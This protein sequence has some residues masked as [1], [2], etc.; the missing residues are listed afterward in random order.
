MAETKASKPKSKLFFFFSTDKGS[1]ILN[2]YQSPSAATSTDTCSAILSPLYNLL[3]VEEETCAL[4]Q[5]A[6]LRELSNLLDQELA[7]VSVREENQ[8]K[9]VVQLKSPFN[10]PF[11]R[12][13]NKM[14][15]SEM[16]APFHA[17]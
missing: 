5:V 12:R 1:P 16:A 2:K 10:S 13:R 8:I 11:L 3:T 15:F 17:H 14:G 4:A 9:A 7:P 6:A